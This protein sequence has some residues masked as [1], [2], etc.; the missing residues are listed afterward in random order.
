MSRVMEEMITEMVTNEKKNVAL[1]MLERGKYTN[2]EI[3][4]NLELPLDVIKK[5]A[6][7]TERR[8]HY[9]DKR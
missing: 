4:E 5:L 3:A 8:K 6:E 2:E 9:K 1:R 7:N